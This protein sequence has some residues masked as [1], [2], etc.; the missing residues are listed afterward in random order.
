[1]V[2]AISE[3][4]V[5]FVI[6][7]RSKYPNLVEEMTVRSMRRAEFGRRRMSG[8]GTSGRGP[9]PRRANAQN[10][11]RKVDAKHSGGP[12]RETLRGMPARPRHAD[13]EARASRV[14]NWQT[15]AG[16]CAPPPVPRRRRFAVGIEGCRY[17]FHRNHSYYH[18]GMAE[19]ADG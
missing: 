10:S 15:G 16:E 13:V 18:S 19:W 3:S 8:A 12:R 11:W 5:R 6:L 7:A 2:D 4:V 9:L 14:A 1:M 17:F